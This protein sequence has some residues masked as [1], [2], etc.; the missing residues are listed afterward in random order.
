MLTDESAA[1]TS[2]GDRSRVS[3][4]SQAD[5]CEHFSRVAGRPAC[6]CDF[7]GGSQQ[8]AAEIETSIKIGAAH[9]RL[10]P[11]VSV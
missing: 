10:D 9:G 8:N 1:V 11:L 5:K 6:C 2:P 7:P 4:G 3:L